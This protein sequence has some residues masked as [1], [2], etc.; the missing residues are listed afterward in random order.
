VEGIV[1]SGQGVLIFEA[2]ELIRELVSRW[3]RD[4][5]Y[6]LIARWRYRLFG[7]W[8]ACPLPQREWAQRFLD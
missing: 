8:R 4:A 2:D 7:P 5:G 1:Q 3:L 6:R